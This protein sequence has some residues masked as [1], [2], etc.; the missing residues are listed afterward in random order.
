MT[1]SED[2]TESVE[3]IALL[4]GLPLDPAYRLGVVANFERI[5]AIA[6]LVMEFPLPDESEAAPVFEP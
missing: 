5:Q 4:I 3:S 1:N 2:L 6:H